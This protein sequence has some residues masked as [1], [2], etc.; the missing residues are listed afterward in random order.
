MLP[1]LVLAS[2]LC[3]SAQTIVVDK[4]TL[5]F[6]GQLAGSAVTQTINITSSNGSAIPFNLAYPSYPWLKVN[7]QLYGFNGT[8]PA[9]ITVT[10]DPTGLS[11]G[12]FSGSIA[13]TGGSSLSN[14]PIAVTFTVS[15]IGVSPASLAFNYTSGSIVFPTPQSLALYGA[16]TQCSATVANT[17]GGNWFTLLQTSCGSP[18]SLTVL[19]NNGVVAGLAPNTYNGTITIA[20]V[21]AGQ[22][23]AVVV[24]VTLTVVPTPPVTVNPP[25][26]VFNWQT[27]IAAPNPSQVLTVST[28]AA[29]ALTYSFTATG[30][31]ISTVSPPSGSIT[32]SAQITVTLNPAGLA[33]GTY[34]GK[35]T[36]L[37]P[38]GSPTQ[39]DIAVTLNVS[40]APLLNVPN[41]TLNFAYQLG[42]NAP[43]AQTVNI[44]ATSGTLNYAVTQSANSPWLSVP[45][46]GNTATPLTVSVNPAGLTAGTYSATVNVT[47]A[48]Q[49]SSAQQIP[50]VLKVTNDPTIS[51][52]AGRLS[53]PYQIGQSTPATQSV[54]ITSSTGVPLNYTASLATTTC[55]S[56]WLLATNASGS[57][58]GVTDDTLT[59]SVATGGLVAATCTG[60]ITINATNPATGA[61]AVNSPLTI[62]VTLYVSSS[63]LL[64]LTPANPPPFT[65]GVGAQSPAPQN[66]TL[67]STNS[68]V[69]TYNVAFQSNN[70]NWLFVGPLNG[71][72][73]A[74][75]IL[76]VSVITSGLAAGS[77][78]GTVTIA[79]S[80]PAGAVVANSPIV[81]PITLNVTAGSLT[82]SASDL[83]FQQT[84]GGTTPA[85]QTVTI[86]SSGQ[87][88]N[89]TALAN[90]NNASV[91]W[92]SISPASGNTSTSGTLIVSVDGSRLTA[93]TT[94]N[95]T[96]VV[97]S[98]GAGNSPATI[99][100][101]FRVDPGTL[102]APTTTLTFTQVA[103]GAVP[104]SQSISVTG[105]PA[106]LSFT[107]TSSTLN[108]VNW[109]R[110]T[111]ATGTT[112]ATVQVLADGTVL[113]V[114]Q[115]T[116][117]V[118]I[119]STGASGSPIAIGVI[120]NVV[121]P[122]VL[123]VSPANLSFAYIAGATAA[124]PVQNLLVTST[125][126]AGSVPISV[127]VQ[128]D[129]TIGQW[130]F[131]TPTSSSAPAT[132]AV[133][134]STANLTAGTYTGRIIVT[135]P[136]ALVAA[137]VNVT[138]T[139]AAIPQPVVSAVANAANYS[140]GAVSPGENIVI[141]GT[142]VGPVTLAQATVVNNAF[143]TLL[144]AT[145]V[146]FDGTAAPI[147]Y[148]SATQTSVMVP[149]GVAGR[150]TTT[151]VVEY[152]GVQS[153]ALTYSVVVAAP[154][155]YTLNA[156][157]TGPGAIL[158]QD[159]SVNGQ[160]NPEKRG[161]I[162]AI[163]MTGEGQTNPGGVDGL[164]I[165]AVAS[166]LKHPILPV[167]V[168]IGGIDAPV[169]YSGS[170][171]GLISG[172][173]QVNV[174][175]PLAAPVGTQPVVVTVGTAKS[176]SGAGAATVVVQ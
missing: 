110:A 153:T 116:G 46:A 162:I 55:G 151:I 129:G 108:G 35:L 78:T 45:N 96:I 57:L 69:L 155:V 159:Y 104:A 5:A 115:Y 47:S 152:S 94:Y 113:G 127:Q 100:V 112:P 20:P 163:Y 9:A 34:T 52:S 158:N 167:S 149:Y 102:S 143:P 87:T 10:A 21:P 101:H 33:P 160:S 36:L 37:T 54:K 68:D 137:T 130:L 77:Y 109:L 141:F 128:F 125:G 89:Y 169:L 27:G 144:G 174:T 53:F 32:G 7:G 65:A 40:N 157:G 82:L 60:S 41:A 103:G 62:P 150:V 76:T 172:V 25:S 106:A 73:S 118:T 16:V 86:G 1:L 83:S 147:I 90:S 71:T 146:L 156:Q 140:T 120:L 80:G 8:T 19:I 51:A 136:N 17:S 59:V 43:A 123:A 23:T 164:V 133:S 171:P 18:G 4:T 122:A 44:T 97:T 114:G 119:A 124:P 170:A 2:A 95:G 142:G 64:V 166:A 107:V 85:S 48:T 63:A 13:V 14:S 135:S 24:P 75:N 92:L 42:T 98:P 176:Q 29:Q 84:L 154:G 11:A 93:G 6:S 49:G 15:A 81:I 132:L 22:G 175:I 30:S 38:G 58:S 111:P 145:R 79:A 139:V 67:G 138:L 28:T 3:L 31:W 66:F 70:G 88:L 131:V 173:M 50:V 39:Q 161:N 126:T 165:P 72:T 12:T 134:I 74:N 99:N 105:T 121:P 168:T 61:A 148:V 117:T 91:N 26:L 56:A